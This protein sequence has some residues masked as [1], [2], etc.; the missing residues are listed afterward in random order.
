MRT[1]RG[2]HLPG[3]LFFFLELIKPDKRVSR[4]S[5]GIGVSVEISTERQRDMVNDQFVN[6]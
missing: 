3:S 4:N 2:F 5:V 1:K 6:F